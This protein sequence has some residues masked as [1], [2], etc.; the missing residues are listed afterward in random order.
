MIVAELLNK[1]EQRLA[2]RGV[3]EAR[4]NA[5]FLMASVLKTGRASLALHASRT[6]P[7]R[8]QN[9]FW[10]LVMGRAKRLPLAYVLG[11]QP[12]CGLDIQVSEGALVPRPETEE[13][14]EEAT[15][16]LKPRAGEPLQILELGTGTGCIAV[17][18]AS[19]FPYASIWATDISP[20]ALKLAQKNA[21]FHHVVHRIRF[22]REDIFKPGHDR[23]GWADL[24]ISN[25]PYIPTRELK[26]LQAEVQ[27]EPVL[28]LDGGPDGLKAIRAIV[29]DAPA[30]LKAGGC[31]MLE[32]GRDQ[33]PAVAAL[34]QERGFAGAMIRKDAQGLDRVAVGTWPAK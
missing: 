3:P 26:G 15:R 19:R 28:A 1:G 29:Q 14:V 8:Q 25:P 21:E 17:A 32:I 31:L 18:L 9:A 30:H 2:E 6:L 20:Q 13:L 4:A 12:F 27:N 16:L 24:V 7:E 23:K 11:S 34:L 10:N 22:I 5:E 33:G